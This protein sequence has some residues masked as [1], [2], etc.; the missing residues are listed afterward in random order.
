MLRLSRKWHFTVGRYRPILLKK[1]VKDFN[2]TSADVPINFKFHVDARTS[3]LAKRFYTLW[4]DCC[5][6]IRA[7]VDLKQALCERY[8]TLSDS[9]LKNL[10]EDG[11]RGTVATY[12]GKDII[13][14]TRG[15]S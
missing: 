5:R 7:G 4:A 9:V 2:L 6:S 14:L 13:D 8:K 15:C 3:V 1:S 12:A 10:T 11:S